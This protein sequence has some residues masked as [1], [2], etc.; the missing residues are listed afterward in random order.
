[1]KLIF[2]LKKEE[3]CKYW[4]PFGITG[5]V[6]YLYIGYISYSV[7]YIDGYE[8]PLFFDIAAWVFRM[9]PVY[10][11]FFLSLWFYKNYKKATEILKG[12]N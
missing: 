3:I 6:I 10:V 8:I 11:I 9:W 4:Y 12:D 7:K 1:M 5:A 2:K